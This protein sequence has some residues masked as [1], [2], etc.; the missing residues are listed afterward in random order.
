MFK[1]YLHYHFLFN[2]TTIYY[3]YIYIYIFSFLQILGCTAPLVKC[4]DVLVYVGDGRFHLEAAM[5]ANPTLR[6]FRYDPYEKRMTEEHYSHQIMLQTRLTMIE[7]AKNAERFGLILGTLGRQ[8]NP[9]VLKQFQNKLQAV[10]KEGI[11]ILLS[12]IFPDKIKLFQNL[13]SFIQVLY[14]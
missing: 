2:N 7:K 14:Y 1:F 10:D 12:E 9:A 13:D 3:I 4:A 8:G 6:A 5:I 11:I